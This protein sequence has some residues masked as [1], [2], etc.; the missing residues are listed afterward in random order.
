MNFNRTLSQIERA[1][2]GGNL[3]G[4]FTDVRVYPQN[5]Q[6]T[7]S[8]DEWVRLNILQGGSTQ[9]GYEKEQATNG[10]IICNVFVPVKAG[11]RRAMSI[12]DRLDTILKND[13]S[14]NSGNITSG[15]QTTNSFI[16]TIGVDSVDS[17]LFRID[18]TINFNQYN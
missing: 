11:L 17:G 13:S 14:F 4:S 5:Y 9:I 15:I 6:G 7:I 1:F 10:Q 3:G 2:T 18:Y 8:T 12:A 16:T